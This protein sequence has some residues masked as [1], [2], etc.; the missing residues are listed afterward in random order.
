MLS[1]RIATE[2]VRRLDR[3]DTL[4]DAEFRVFSQFGEDGILEWLVHHVAPASTCFVEFGVENYLEANT[5]FLLLN[6]N[7]KGFVMDGNPKHM[8][9]VR[10]TPLYWRNDLRAVS[11]FITAE[12]IDELL[13]SNGFMGPLGVL[14]VDLDGNDYWVLKAMR[15]VEADI[16][17]VEC[18]PIFGD[19]HAVT[20]PYDP[21]FERFSAHYSGLFFGASIQA[22]RELAEQRG[23]TFV[24]TCTNGI[25]AFFVSNAR[26]PAI[27]DRIGRRVAWP[28]LHRDS[29]NQQ[30]ELS[31]VRGGARLELIADCKVHCCR[32]NRLV[33][34]GSLER[35]YSDEW[36]AAMSLPGDRASA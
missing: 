24:G 23:Y 17:I 2:Q 8:E 15:R 25:N 35:P 22:V 9:Y 21:G 36:L 29:R 26:Y 31:Y 3:I 5:R 14:S 12:N 33:R 1:A 34:L 32:T 11:A 20:V 4:A 19:R 27:A 13:E 7:W 18:N 16:L 6:R 30:H 28:A 10:S